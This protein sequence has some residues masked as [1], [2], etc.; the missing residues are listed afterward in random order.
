MAMRQLDDVTSGKY[1]KYYYIN[2]R[3]L[4]FAF[5]SIFLLMILISFNHKIFHQFILLFQNNIILLIII[6]KLE[7]NFIALKF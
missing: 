5:M 4:A 1:L 6:F 2:L 7:V 3:P